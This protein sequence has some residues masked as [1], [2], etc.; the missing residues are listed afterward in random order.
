MKNRTKYF[1]PLLLILAACGSDSEVAPSGG[2][3]VTGTG[4]SMARFTI[5]GDYLYAVDQSKLVTFS[6]ASPMEPAKVDEFQLDLGV[7]TIFA[8]DTIVFVGTQT[9]MHMF[10][11]TEGSRP[12]YLSNYEHITSCDPVVAQDTLAFVTLRSGSSCWNGS[13]QLD[14]ID[15]RDLRNPKLIKSYDM[16]NP[17]GL[18]VD[19]NHLF[20][21]EG[22][23]GLKV[24]EIGA[25]G[26][27]E[28]IKFYNSIRSQDV[29]VRGDNLLMVVAQDGLFQ[30]DY[31]DI[32]N[33][34]LL[35]QLK[36][37]Y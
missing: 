12:G 34:E 15:I 27:L 21:S 23:Y 28:L 3:D 11:V 16:Q 33:I 29:I 13:N 6:I 2:A 1:L 8:M 4:G 20:V 7:E 30:Y 14:V 37:E 31:S 10:D 5:S 36:I 19:G 9:G 24:F 17:H 32:R 26:E 22:D 35:S 25:G 18:G